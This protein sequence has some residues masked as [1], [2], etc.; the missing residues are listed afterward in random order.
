MVDKPVAAHEFLDENNMSTTTL[1][2]KILI[3]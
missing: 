3:L 2:W 1:F